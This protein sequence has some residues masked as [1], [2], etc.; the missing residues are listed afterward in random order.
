MMTPLAFVE[1]VG[2]WRA[3]C[4]IVRPQDVAFFTILMPIAATGRRCSAAKVQRG[5]RRDIRRLDVIMIEA[6]TGLSRAVESRDQ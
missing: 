3:R 1:E 4:L 6:S 2:H 5:W